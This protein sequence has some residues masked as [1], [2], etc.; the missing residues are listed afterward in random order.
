MIGLCESAVRTHMSTIV[1]RIRTYGGEVGLSLDDCGDGG[2]VRAGQGDSSGGD[3]ETEKSCE[4]CVAIC[5]V[6]NQ[7]HLNSYR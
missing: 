7:S 1:D 3:L 4:L 5:Q 2:A 6:E